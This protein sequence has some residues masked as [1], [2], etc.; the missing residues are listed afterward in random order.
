MEE[1][2]TT[3][4]PKEKKTHDKQE[5]VIEIKH[6]KKSFGNKDVLKDINLVVHRGE[7]VVVLGKSGQGKSVTIQ[8]IVGML[9]P[10]DGTLKIISS[11]PGLEIYTF[12]FG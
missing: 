12:T 5:V 11:E 2:A 4:E 1:K 8:C 7:N 10:D 9:I 6:L 3:A